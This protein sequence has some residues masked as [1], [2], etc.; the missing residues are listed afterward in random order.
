M[1]SR[2]YSALKANGGA[3]GRYIPILR[4]CCVVLLLSMYYLQDGDGGC[5]GIPIESHHYFRSVLYY[6]YE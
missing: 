6:D 3:K 4:A 1:L 2:F 5:G